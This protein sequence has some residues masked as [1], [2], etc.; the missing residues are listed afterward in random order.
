MRKAKSSRKI[1]Y[2]YLANDIMQNS[3]KKTQ[4]FIKGFSEVLPE[5]I[6]KIWR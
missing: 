5:V 4:D 3:R 1:L 6:D 2:L